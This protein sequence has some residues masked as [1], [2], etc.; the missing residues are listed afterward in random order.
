MRRRESCTAEELDHIRTY[1]IHDES[2]ITEHLDDL[3][4]LDSINEAS[5]LNNLR[6][7]FG[8]DLIY[9]SLGT[10][11]V[12]VNPLKWI[13]GMYG[14][15]VVARYQGS[16]ARGETNLK[17]HVYATAERA[18]YG[19]MEHGANQSIV[20][21]GESGAGK[22]E[23]KK[24]SPILRQWPK[25]LVRRIAFLRRTPFSRRSGTPK[26]CAMTTPPA[27]VNGWRLISTIRGVLWVV[28]IRTFCSKKAVLL[29]RK[30]A[31]ETITPFYH[32]LS[33]ADEDLRRRLHLTS[34]PEDFHYT[35]Q[36]GVYVLPG[37]P[38]E[39]EMWTELQNAFHK[40]AFSSQE[41]FGI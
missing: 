35:N 41:I 37:R 24:V 36:T 7:R 14:D 4:Q 9:T 23:A 25:S 39:A 5:I 26:P 8:N 15:D 6:V 11:T 38:S 33:C 16:S 28:P 18:Y 20:I 31:N 1:P 30:L 13:K 12:A 3:V 22:T 2:S 32:L 21:S 27:S 40:L 17:P 10:I 29:C 34:G 19:L